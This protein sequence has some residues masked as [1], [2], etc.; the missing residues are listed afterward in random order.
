MTPSLAALEFGRVL[1]LVA[2]FARSEQGKNTVRQALPRFSGAGEGLP[3]SRVQQ[4][5]QLVEEAGPLPFAGLDGVSL[6]TAP[7]PPSAE[8]ATLAALVVLVRRIVETRS[9]LLS[10]QTC[11]EWLATL[12]RQ[13]PDFSPLLSFCERRLGPDGEVLDTASPTLAQAR[14]ARERHRAAILATL[15]RLVRQHRGLAGPPTVRRERYCLPVPAS[16]RHD[17]PGLTLDVSGSGSTLF[18]EP[19]GVV[20][21]NNAFAEATARAQEEEERVR[22]EVVAA[23]QSSR[24]ELVQAAAELA[25]LD[26]LQARVLFGKYAGGVLVAPGSAGYLRLRGA[27]HPLL[28][29]R[30]APLRE[31]VLGEAGNCGPV[32]PLDLDLDS[33]ARVMLLSGPNAGG[34]TV[35]LKTVGLSVV[36][37]YAGIPVLADE[38]SVLPAL[39]GVWCRIGDDQDLLEDRSTFSAAMNAT[40]SLL[41]TVDAT[42]LV[43]Y[44]ELG[45]GTD[46]EE[47]AALAAALLEELVRRGCWVVATAHLVTV[48]AHLE[49]LPGAVNAAMGYDEQNGRPTYR[50]AVGAPGRSHGLAIARRC[51]LPERVI[52]RASELVSQGFLTIDRYLSRLD[53]E[54]QRLLAERDALQVAQREAAEARAA[55]EAEAARLEEARRRLERQWQEE[56]ERL[57]QRAADQLGRALSELQQARERGEF[58]GKRRIAALRHTAL[59]LGAGEA[60]ATP[61]ETLVPGARVA[62]D[63]LRATGVVARLLGDRAEVVVGAKRI[64]VERSAC[65]RTGDSPTPT[66]AVTTSGPEL[67][68]PARELKLIGLTQEEA[69]ERLESFLDQAILAGAKMVRIVHGHGTGA[70]RRLVREVVSAHPAVVHVSSPPQHLGGTGVTEVELE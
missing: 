14:A 27:R 65:H 7:A 3:S 36:M 5:W 46:P 21:L 28:D 13:L 56:R 40:A 45:S 23:F 35:A 26:A 57:R 31:Q 10:H 29:P 68:E 20:D 48:A 52:Q 30:L 51:G 37:A 16:Q 70:L 33:T 2:S 42:T 39:G 49:R 12:A 11:G 24:R 47:G 58:P 17:V 59:D 18:V 60:G 22:G 67:P 61:A 44:D 69:R 25:E 19:F 41:A 62:I 63:G 15:E 50:L 34:K 54:R 43:L 8:P 66:A 4:V 38:T 64:W 6:L 55:A 32:T 9:V 53:E 1:E